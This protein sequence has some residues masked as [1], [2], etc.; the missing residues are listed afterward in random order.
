MD[1][2]YTPPK[3]DVTAS[4]GT[5]GVTN[6]MLNAMG[7][8]KPWVLLIGIL[9]IIGAVFVFIGAVGMF[10]VGARAGVPGGM[11]TIMA[12]MYLVFGV[13]YIFLGLYL[14]KYSSAIG[15]LMISREP[16]DLESALI[17]QKSFWKL[18]GIVALIGIIV[19]IIAMVAGMAGLGMMGTRGF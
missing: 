15:R 3:S 2:N 19:G 13:V 11:V 10:A 14:I 17:A 4:S 9:S 16:G 1:N 5:G 18:A 7:A 8:T 6:T 12:V